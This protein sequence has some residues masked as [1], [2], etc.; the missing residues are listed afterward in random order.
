[1]IFKSLF[2]KKN[3]VR[4]IILRSV[5]YALIILALLYLYH[6]RHFGDVAFIYNEF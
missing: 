1:M 4:D 2:K 3:H 5:F 6:Y